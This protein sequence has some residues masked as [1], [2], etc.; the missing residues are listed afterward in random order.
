MQEIPTLTF[1]V[2]ILSLY[3]RMG[4]RACLRLISSLQAVK[5]HALNFGV[6]C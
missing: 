5:T 2:S 3:T 1:S 4:N 6:T